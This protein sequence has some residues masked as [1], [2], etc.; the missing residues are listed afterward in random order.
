MSLSDYMNAAL[1]RAVYHFNAED[2]LIYGEIPD[3]EGLKTNGK[4]VLECRE[5]LS[6]LLE[7]WIYFHVSRGIPVP[8]I[9]GI[10]VPIREIF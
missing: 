3:L 4:T 6:E 9:N 7:D 8:V 2:G 5:R 1:E 10:E